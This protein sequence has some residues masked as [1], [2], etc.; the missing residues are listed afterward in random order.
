MNVLRP[1]LLP[2]LL[3]S[4]R[5]VISR[6]KPTTWH[7]LRL[8]ACLPREQPR[9]APLPYCWP[10]IGTPH[11]GKVTTKL[12]AM[13]LKGAVEALLDSLGVSVCNLPDAKRQQRCLWNRLN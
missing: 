11:F 13:D 5:S 1:S 8:A 7:F 2:G 9:T 3:D 4:M 12:D 6:A 10:V